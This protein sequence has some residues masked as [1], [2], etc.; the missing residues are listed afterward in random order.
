MG[1]G[2]YTIPHFHKMYRRYFNASNLKDFYLK[3]NDVHAQL[4]REYPGIK[5]PTF[6]Y[7][8]KG[9][10]LFMNYRSTRGLFD[11]FEGVVKG[12]AQFMKE[13]V[14]VTVKPLDKNTARAEIRFLKS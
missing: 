3:M 2:M 6:T 13:R 8:D 12:A 1:L 14:E 9:D 10:V 7:E 5:P 4:T 11:Y